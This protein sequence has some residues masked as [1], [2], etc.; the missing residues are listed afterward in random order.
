MIHKD[1]TDSQ[2]DAIKKYL[3]K[4]AKT[5]R[6]RCD[7]RITI[8]GILLVLSSGCRWGELPEKYGTKSTAH[9]RFQKLQ[10]LGVWHKI[11]ASLIK[12]A[13]KQH[14]LSL[15]KILVDSSSVPAKKRAT[16]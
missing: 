4:P 5:G 1:M 6:P 14:K 8:D 10:E 12:R 13:H 11:L 7:D 16:G 9:L 15:K 2:W 3:P